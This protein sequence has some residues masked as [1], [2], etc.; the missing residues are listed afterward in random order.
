MYVEV[1]INNKKFSVSDWFF[2]ADAYG[3]MWY[4]STR[5]FGAKKIDYLFA[6]GLGGNHLIVIP[7]ENMIIALT[8]SA[9]GQR[10]QHGR[11]FAIMSKIMTSL[12]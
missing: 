1:L 2:L 9:Y 10:Y 4:K 7:K 8:S 5:K 3:T 12:K 6:S 11:S